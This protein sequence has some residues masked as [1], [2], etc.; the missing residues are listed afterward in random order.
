MITS[1]RLVN[2]QSWT[3]STINLTSGFNV[4]AAPN[5][6]GKSVLFKIL[7]VTASP[8][9]Y[10]AK[11][12]RKI[13]RWGCKDAKAVYAFSSGAQGLVV[14]Q[15]NNVLY[16]YRKSVEENW[17]MSY[18]PAPEMIQE[19][20]LLVNANGNFIANIIDTDQNLLLVDS[21]A[22]G[23]YEFIDMLCN[24]PGLTQ[25]K[26]KLDFLKREMDSSYTNALSRSLEI[27]DDLQH[28]A[29]VDVEKIEN[30]LK[31]TQLVN[32]IL[33]GLID[34]ANLTEIVRPL[35]ESW[36][37]FDKL[38][39]DCEKL[40]LLENIDV[41]SLQI[42]EYN[43][44][45]EKDCKI[46][47]ILETLNLTEMFIPEK[48]MDYEELNILEILEDIKMKDVYV[49]DSPIDADLCD[50]LEKLEKINDC[51]IVVSE[52]VSISANV[53][54]DISELN[55]MFLS[56]GVVHSCE[57]FEKVIYDGTTCVP[58]ER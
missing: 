34:V 39:S 27:E 53:L 22:K 5:N 30:D 44:E 18:E 43:K 25:Y 15:P 51:V 52:Q 58:V 40:N 8:K 12:R 31:T 3:D 13:I 6:T 4:I 29:Y 23:T 35:S 45:L 20:G 7:K 2:C 41:S 36:M 37:D 16:G 49:G 11:K 26:D 55:E 1:I 38:L 48:P 33:F 54:K 42:P 19:V 50:V 21:D 24:H 28:Y 47:E 56:S 57:I 14:I 17:C 46:L 10:K 32:N 9:Y